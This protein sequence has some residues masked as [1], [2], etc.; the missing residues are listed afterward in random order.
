MAKET[1]G[2][3]TKRESEMAEEV[4]REWPSFDDILRE[5]DA[6]GAARV[7][8]VESSGL[9]D[10]A[11]LD[12]LSEHTRG[13]LNVELVSSP[14]DAGESVP[15]DEPTAIPE[16]P[17]A[18][19]DPIAPFA[20]ETPSVSSDST[21]DAFD[22]SALEPIPEV[23]IEPLPEIEPEVSE[24]DI[25]EPTEDVTP[26]EKSD[27]PVDIEATDGS[28]TD[29]PAADVDPLTGAID[30]TSFDEQAKEEAEGPAD[31]ALADW[32]SS[33]PSWAAQPTAP[34]PFVFDQDDDPG[35]KAGQIVELH[36]SD[37][38]T[39]AS[40]VTTS[41]DDPDGFDS[42]ATADAIESDLSELFDI[43]SDATD[44]EPSNVIPIHTSAEDNSEAVM[45]L[46]GNVAAG[47]PA[48]SPGA[49]AGK[50]NKQRPEDPW[51]YMR[52]DPEDDIKKGFWKNRPK[53]FGGD[54]RKARRA[55]R[56]AELQAMIPDDTTSSPCTDCGGKSVVDLQ[57]PASGKLHLS[58]TACKKTWTEYTQLGREA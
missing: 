49:W 30:W 29:I 50:R 6:A 9:T 3:T 36:S 44:E 19:A 57:D 8:R 7:R 16:A 20:I 53:F 38:K 25:E 33:E 58:C 37:D 31:D 10:P 39:A 46:D 54:E 48:L 12:T 18:L 5:L 21:V 43:E 52:P 26:V 34:E 23:E 55:E 47:E 24:A 51:A 15:A 14:D 41:V 2:R 27:E 40:W 4:K 1:Q 13:E 42:V 56:E 17:A 11:G 35:L 32:A 45:G 22:T 28:T